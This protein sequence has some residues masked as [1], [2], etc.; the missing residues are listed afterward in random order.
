MS[1]PAAYKVKSQ[2]SEEQRVELIQPT[3]LQWM[4]NPT[5]APG[6]GYLADVDYLAARQDRSISQMITGLTSAQK[7]RISNSLGQI[8]Y[9][10]F[11]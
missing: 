3:Q 4:T 11:E 9:F 1:N 8:V 2:E 5:S 10:A 7:F 6:L